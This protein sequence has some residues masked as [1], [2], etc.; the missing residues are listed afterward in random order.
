MKKENVTLFRRKR[1]KRKEKQTYRQHA[2]SESPT[3][4][5]TSASLNYEESQKNVHFLNEYQIAL[6]K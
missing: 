1:Q 5:D 2:N 4:I 6:I 3:S